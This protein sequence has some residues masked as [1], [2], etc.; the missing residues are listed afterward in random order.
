[1]NCSAIGMVDQSHLQL[2]CEPPLPLFPRDFVDSEESSKYWMPSSESD[3]CDP[4][5]SWSRVRRLYEGGW[6]RLPIGK[7]LDLK[8]V[9]WSKLLLTTATRDDGDATDVKAAH[10]VD[11]VA[12]RGPYGTP[13]VTVLEGCGRMMEST[14]NDGCTR[15]RRNRRRTRPT[16]ITTK[17]Q[18]A[19]KDEVEEWRQSVRSLLVS[20]SLPAV[21]QAHIVVSGKGTLQCGDNLLVGGSDVGVVTAGSFSSSRGYCHGFGIIGAARLLKI[22]SEDNVPATFGRI[23][24]LLNGQVQRRIAGTVVSSPSNNEA[25]DVALSLLL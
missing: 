9:Q 12:V 11:V 18:P 15:P 6:G 25:Q 19:G 21:L 8:G 16:Y 23:T 5:T 24:R 3:R 20:L 2:E 4:Q 17:V 13:F 22:L 14:T 10:D 1:M 7:S